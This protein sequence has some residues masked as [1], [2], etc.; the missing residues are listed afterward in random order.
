MKLNLSIVAQCTGGIALITLGVI[1]IPIA[2]I[3][4]IVA[5]CLIVL[6]SFWIYSAVTND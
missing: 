5:L 1:L 3:K 2:I 6:G 4:T